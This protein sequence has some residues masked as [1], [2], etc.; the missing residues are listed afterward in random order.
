MVQR[1]G[2]VVHL[3]TRVTSEDLMAHR[4]DAVILATGATPLQGVFPGGERMG[5]FLASEVLKGEVEI[6]IPADAVV[7][8][9]GFRSNRGLAE[10]LTGTGLDVHLIGDALEPRG[11]GEA[12]WEGFQIA[13]RL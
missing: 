5:W 11:A 12:I 2:A 1:T 8:A 10:G 7:L 13:A 3:G 4:P 9:V 6:S